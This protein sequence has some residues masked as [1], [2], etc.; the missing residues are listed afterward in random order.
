MCVNK[1]IIYMYKKQESVTYFS[2]LYTE[3]TLPPSGCQTLC[4][5]NVGTGLVHY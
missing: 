1:V 2:V 3:K 4:I 5:N